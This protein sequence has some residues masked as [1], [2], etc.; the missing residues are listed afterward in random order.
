MFD[1]PFLYFFQDGMLVQE[2]VIQSLD[3]NE[4]DLVKE[5]E[6]ASEIGS[7]DTQEETEID[8]RENE[9]GRD[10][11][12]LNDNDNVAIE[13]Q[14]QKIKEPI[15]GQLKGEKTFDRFLDLMEIF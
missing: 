3:L 15:S 9:E 12:N 5:K 14:I 11:E 1:V 8:R 7:I 6:T 10:T 2:Q 13:S 4:I